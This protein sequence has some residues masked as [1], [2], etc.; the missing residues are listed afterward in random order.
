MA[1]SE[2]RVSPNLTGEELDTCFVADN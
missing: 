2:I 1:D